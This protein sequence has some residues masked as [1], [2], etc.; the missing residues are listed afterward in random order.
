MKTVAREKAPALV[1]I[2][3]REISLLLITKHGLTRFL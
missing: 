3:V 2:T 1:F